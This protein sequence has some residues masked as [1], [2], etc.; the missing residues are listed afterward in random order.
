MSEVKECNPA[1]P[2]QAMM[3]HLDFLHHP[4]DAAFKNMNNAAQRR[5]LLDAFPLVRANYQRTC[6]LPAVAE[7]KK[8]RPAFQGF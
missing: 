3:I 7:W 8:R 4:D 6:A 2:Y 5:K 1:L